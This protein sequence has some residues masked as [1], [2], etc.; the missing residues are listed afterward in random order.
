MKAKQKGFGRRVRNS[1]YEP[2]MAAV[3]AGKVPNY[4]FLGYD[5]TTWRIT[6]GFVVP[7]NFI[8]ASVIERAKPSHVRGRKNPWFGSNILLGLLPAD[9]RVQLVEGERPR[10]PSLVRKEWR[11]FDFLKGRKVEERGWLADTLRVVRELDSP[12]F[13]LSDVYAHEEELRGLHPDNRHIVPKIRQQVQL[14]RDKGVLRSLG[15]GRYEL[16]R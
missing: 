6:S 14:L 16:V 12:R 9:A 15:A 11:R 8:T 10:E 2:K 7:S 5:R 13:H 1:A 4:V 3:R